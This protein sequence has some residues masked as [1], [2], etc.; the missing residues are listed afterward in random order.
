MLKISTKQHYVLITERRANIRKAVRHEK[1][2]DDSG[3]RGK[4]R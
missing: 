2:E 1:Q 3:R 4:G